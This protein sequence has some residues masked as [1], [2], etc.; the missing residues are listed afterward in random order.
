M[1]GQDELIPRITGRCLTDDLG[2][3]REALTWDID[4]LASAHEIIIALRDRAHTGQ[5]GQEPIR[6]LLPEIPAFSLHRGRWRGAVWHHQEIDVLWLLAAGFHRAGSRND[7][8][9]HFT[10]LKANGAILPTRDD[11]EAFAAGEE[12]S[13]SAVLAKEAPELLM[14]LDAS[15]PREVV[16]ARLGGRIDVK[17]ARDEAGR[18]ELAVSTKLRPGKTELDANWLVTVAAAF[19]PAQQFEDLLWA[20]TFAGGQTGEHEL[21]FTSS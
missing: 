8:Y 20:D 13:L 5:E 4:R 16:S 1:P 12:H 18:I 7:A 2:L 14:Q 11:F 17:L 15:R 19:F 9:E 21:V 6:A 10:R 3:S